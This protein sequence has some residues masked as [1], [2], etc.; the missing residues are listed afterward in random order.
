MTYSENYWRG[1]HGRE[2]FKTNP[3]T[4]VR[5]VR[6]PEMK[7]NKKKKFRFTYT[8]KSLDIISRLLGVMCN[9]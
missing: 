3:A 7:K 8:P 6:K 9:G 5:V 4:M 2:K 1:Q